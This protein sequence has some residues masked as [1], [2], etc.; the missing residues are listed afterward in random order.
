MGKAGGCRACPGG[1]FLAIAGFVARALDA[2]AA[3]PEGG[4]LCPAADTS[5]GW[6]A[7]CGLAAVSLC[8][9]RAA[10]HCAHH[11]AV[12]GEELEL[13]RMNEARTVR[14]DQGKTVPAAENWR[15]GKRSCTMEKDKT[16]RK[17]GSSGWNV[18]DF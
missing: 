6:P 14:T 2:V 18:R 11:G 3:H 15:G 7:Q 12:Q 4:R 16:R 9:A 1:S 8:L 13:A 5:G 17:N 10:S